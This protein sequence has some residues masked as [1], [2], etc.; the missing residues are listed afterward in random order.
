MALNDTFNTF[1]KKTIKLKT[2]L[3]SNFPIKDYWGK[4]C[5]KHPSKKE[6][7]FYCD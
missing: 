3:K 7:L 6:C 2:N 1:Q 4:E 5:E